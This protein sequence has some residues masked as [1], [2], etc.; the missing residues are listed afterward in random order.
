MSIIFNK[1]SVKCKPHKKEYTVRRKVSSKRNLQRVL[2]KENKRFLKSL[3]LTL[4]EN[5]ERQ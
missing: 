3:G 2:S 1:L 5:V 4:F